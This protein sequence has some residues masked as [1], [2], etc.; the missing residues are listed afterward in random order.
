MNK[1][2]VVSVAAFGIVA[3]C[4]VAIWGER[5][6]VQKSE[7]KPNVGLSNQYEN[8]VV[9]PLLEKAA[10]KVLDL[11]LPDEVV[12]KYFGD[13]VKAA[14]AVKDPGLVDKNRLPDFFK[15]TGTPDEVKYGGGIIRDDENEDYINSI[16]GAEIN[17]ELTLD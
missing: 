12:V 11:T 6:A 4:L 2:V 5:N 16:E 13:E 15:N 10:P 9:E 1:L 7:I 14:T 17:V 8:D 3:I